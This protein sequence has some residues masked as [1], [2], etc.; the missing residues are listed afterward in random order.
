MYW[1]WQPPREPPEH[2]SESHPENTTL[3]RLGGGVLGGSVTRKGV[4]L[5]QTRS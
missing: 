2:R 5:W 4:C 1:I 3:K